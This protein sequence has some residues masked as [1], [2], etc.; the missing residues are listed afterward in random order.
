MRRSWRNAAI[1]IAIPKIGWS[2]LRAAAQQRQRDEAHPG[3]AERAV[4]RDLP[5]D[6]ARVWYDPRTTDQR[7]RSS[8]T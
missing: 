2:P 5:D 3:L 1:C 7:A 4:M 8:R 6:F